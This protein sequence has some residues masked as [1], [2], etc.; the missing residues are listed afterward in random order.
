MGYELRR[1]LADRLPAEISSGERLVALEIAD[2]ANEQTRRAYGKSLLQTIARRTGY[3]NEKQVRKVVIRLARNKVE[4]RV[5]ISRN[6]SPVMDKN[7]RPVFAYEGHE[8]TYRIPT[9]AECPALEGPLAGSLSGTPDGGPLESSGTPG[10]T[11]RNPAE[12]QEGPRAGS[13][14]TPSGSPFSSSSPQDSSSL[15]S[16]ERVVMDALNHLGVTEDEMREVIKEIRKATKVKIENP[17]SYFRTIA[18]RGDLPDYLNRVRANTERAAANAARQAQPP[19]VPEQAPD[20]DEPPVT[21]EER[22]AAIAAVREALQGSRVRRGEKGPARVLR[23]RHTAEEVSPAVQAARDYLN[24]RGDYFE[25]M[26]IARDKLSDDAARDEV[27]VLA[28]ELARA[29]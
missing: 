14:G 4:L 26:A 2:Q 27:V 15:L 17:N 20:P 24:R 11:E 13:R 22:E 10:G 9:E 3:A 7:G 18:Q 16:H 8:T 25:W 6:G 23:P 28:A 21:P 19:V 29:K 12:D 1:W 5:P